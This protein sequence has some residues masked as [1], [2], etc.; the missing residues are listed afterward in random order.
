[1]TAAAPVR[2]SEQTPSSDPKSPD[3]LALG[4]P[5]L[6]V[7]PASEQGSDVQLLSFPSHATPKPQHWSS[8]RNPA[9]RLALQLLPTEPQP[10]TPALPTSPLAQPEQPERQMDSVSPLAAVQPSSAL[11]SGLAT[12]SL[13]TPRTARAPRRSEIRTPHTSLDSSTPAEH[14]SGPPPQLCPHHPQKSAQPTNTAS[15]SL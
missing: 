3:S 8:F 2:R 4:W 6:V 10:Q 5:H 7:Q 9:Q 1:M 12:S 11:S 14:G 13:H 15:S